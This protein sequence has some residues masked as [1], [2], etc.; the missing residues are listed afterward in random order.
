MPQMLRCRFVSIGH[1]KARIDDRVLETHVLE[2]ASHTIVWAEN[3]SGKT[4]LLA[5]MLWLL[6]LGKFPDNRSIDEYVLPDDTSFIVIEW[7]LDVPTSSDHSTR[8]LTG[9]CL[10]RKTVSDHEYGSVRRFFFTTRV[11]EEKP[12]LSLTHLPIYISASEHERP[13]LRRFASF[14]TEWQRV[15][16]TAAEAEVTFTEQPGIWK[17]TLAAAGIDPI[18]FGYQMNMNAQEANGGKL[19]QFRNEQHFADQFLELTADASACQQVAQLVDK[20][21]TELRKRETELKPSLQFT[22]SLLEILMPL[23]GAFTTRTH[24]YQEM[25]QGQQQVEVLSDY[26][27]H[28]FQMHQLHH[29]KTLQRRTEAQQMVRAKRQ[30]HEQFTQRATYGRYRAAQYHTQDLMGEVRALSLIVEQSVLQERRWDAAR[31][32]FEVQQTV[33]RIHQLEEHMSQHHN[34]HLPLLVQAQQQG[35]YYR[36]VLQRKKNI[37]Q[38]TSTA[39]REQREMLLKESEQHRQQGE[40]H[41]QKE[42]ALTGY[43]ITLQAQ[44]QKISTLQ[45]QFERKGVFLPGENAHQSYERLENLHSSLLTEHQHLSE[46]REKDQQQQTFLQDQHRLLDKEI[47]E[48][49]GIIK[50]I[51]REQTNRRE[52]REQIETDLWLRNHFDVEQLDLERSAATL[53]PLLERE[54][55]GL[56][57]RITRHTSVL[58][59]LEAVIA[60]LRTNK[61]LPAN[62]STCAVIEILQEA[63]IAAWTGWEYLA[64]TALPEDIRSAIARAPE[65]VTGVVVRDTVYAQTQECLLQHVVHLDD[66]V[67][68]TSTEGLREVQKQARH[69]SFVIGPTTTAR[70]DHHEAQQVLEEKQHQAEQEQQTLR[71]LQEDYRQLR[72]R[73]ARVHLFLQRY[74]AHVVEQQQIQLK[75]YQQECQQKGEESQAFHQRIASVRMRLEEKK[76]KDEMLL[77]QQDEAKKHLY[78]LEPH[79]EAFAGMAALHQQLSQ[80][81]RE[82]QLSQAQA[83]EN[84]AQEQQ[85]RQQAEM[86]LQRMQENER[87]EGQIEYEHQAI[88]YFTGQEGL[89]APSDE[90]QLIRDAYRMRVDEYEQKSNQDELRFRL[91]EL[92]KQEQQEQAIFQKRLPAHTIKDDIA[93]LLLDRSSAEEVEESYREAVVAM[94]RA[95]QHLQMKQEEQKQAR[96]QE[97]PLELQWQQM[98]QDQEVIQDISSMEKHAVFLLVKEAEEQAREAL[99]AVQEHQQLSQN[100]YIAG[101][102][103]EKQL[104]VIQGIGERFTML[105]ARYRHLFEEAVGQEAPLLSCP[106]LTEA[107]LQEYSEQMTDLF[108]TQQ[109]MLHGL[110]QRRGRA[111]KEI[112]E[113]LRKMN[114]TSFH[115]PLMNEFAQ[116]TDELYEQR[117]QQLQE[118]LTTRKQYFESSLANS[119]K[120]HE[121]V[122]NA[123][124]NLANRGYQMLQ[125]LPKH[126]RLP[127]SIS[128]FGQRPCLKIGIKDLSPEEKRM[129]ILSQLTYYTKASEIPHGIKLYQ[130]MVQCIAAPISVQV[131]SL[132]PYK[133]QYV[134]IEEISKGSGGER[135]T[136]T[137]LLYCT[138]VRMREVE[139]TKHH[140]ASSCL[141]LDN[142][143]GAASRPLF[144]E[145]Q[146]EVAQKMKIQLIYFTGVDDPE[147]I[148][149]FPNIISLRNATVD[150]TTGEYLLEV[151]KTDLQTMRAT[152]D[153]PPLL[154]QE[155]KDG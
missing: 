37:L 117:C 31:A 111:G 14:R 3:A 26:I 44:I 146:R 48:L 70:F 106:L 149:M 82:A 85:A 116:Y 115:I 19:F 155:K 121:L 108:Q 97:H 11:F 24:L 28:R 150:V 152:L 43:L 67:A 104:Q 22:T 57:E 34:A 59:E 129:R 5:L 120:N 119:Q 10:E 151:K 142:P 56:E 131:I 77:H 71:R 145:L 76:K 41:R 1:P 47:S 18:L 7:K 4:S 32:L 103:Q 100:F 109:Q 89:F 80:D 15:A 62:A 93:A 42:Q 87:E 63:N 102:E 66:P 49:Q 33:K 154:T 94:L 122:L 123:L 8:Y 55:Q 138:L 68:I 133:P 91:G 69:K 137:V 136:M 105:H 50:S 114:Q 124:L 40:A 99:H 95:E 147:A 118:E 60:S 27:Q 140:F 128:A 113:L 143:V 39:L 78:Q 23:Q 17:E 64:E 61:L 112:Q 79:L 98:T 36:S 83:L 72:E 58:Q 96:E 53:V 153:L 12:G 9:V 127:A 90:L 51:H 74:P 65:I 134:S 13:S 135:L 6:S 84:F 130:E 2:Q 132:D 54:A 126:S 21:R 144:L 30:E 29:Q 81:Q 38:Q 16:R 52:E 88:V 125:D 92:Q 86:L 35:D 139:R 46:S 101:L 75:N 148:R 107:T 141:L 20:H 73:V 25:R 110:N 45:K